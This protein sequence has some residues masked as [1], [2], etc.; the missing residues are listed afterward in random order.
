ML[1][2]MSSIGGFV[3]SEPYFLQSYTQGTANISA[4][5]TI[6]KPVGTISGD[7]LIGTMA[8]QSGNTWT[9]ASG[10]TE[11]IDQGVAPTG[12]AA[13][14]VA[15]GSEPSSYTFTD[16][17][18]SISVGMV[19]C[20]RG[21]QYDTIGGAASTLTGDGTLNITGIT[22]AGGIIIAIVWSNDASGSIAHSTP[23]GFAKIATAISSPN[24]FVGV[25]AFYKQVSAGATGT[26]GINI[27]GTT[28]ENAGVLLGLKP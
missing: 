24:T 12:R 18:A 13:T 7:F 3:A 15:G 16:G 2:G 27:T 21:L 23:S 22:S 17:T 6:N 8:S 28:G 9:G 20:F 5:L 25:S 26:V 14:L 10:W 11:R 4:S 1:P 19:L